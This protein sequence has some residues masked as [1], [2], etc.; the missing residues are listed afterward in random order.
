VSLSAACPWASDALMPMAVT[1][2]DQRQADAVESACQHFGVG[3]GELKVDDVA[4]VTQ[5]RLEQHYFFFEFHS[6]PPAPASSMPPSPGKFSDF[7]IT[8]AEMS[9]ER[10]V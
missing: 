7:G 3:R 5:R 4:A 8:S 2:F 1:D 6:G 9:R 10:Q